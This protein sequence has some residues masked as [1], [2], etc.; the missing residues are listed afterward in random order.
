MGVCSQ[1]TRPINQEDMQRVDTLGFGII[2][3]Y[4]MNPDVDHPYQHRLAGAG[5]TRRNHLIR[6]KSFATEKNSCGNID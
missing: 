5:E 3:Y 4:L 2:M 6:F 1:P